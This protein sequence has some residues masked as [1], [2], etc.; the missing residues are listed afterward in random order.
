M[1]YFRITKYN[2]IF[3]GKDD[4]YRGKD[5]WTEYFMAQ[6]EPC[7]LQDYMIVEQNYIDLLLEIFE[8]LKL[9]A[10]TFNGLML[11]EEQN[12]SFPRI[13]SLD[14]FIHYCLSDNKDKLN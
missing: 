1:E 5:N 11:F 4:I 3:R 2:P 13:L 12:R 7:L 14:S 8:N 10:L 6:E 9:D